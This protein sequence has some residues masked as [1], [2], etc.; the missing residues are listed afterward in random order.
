[1]RHRD[2]YIWKL[3]AKK[4]KVLEQFTA[5]GKWIGSRISQWLLVRGTFKRIAEKDDCGATVRKENVL[6]GVVLRLA[7]PVV[8]LFTFVFGARNGSLG[9]IVKKGEAL[10]SVSTLNP[11]RS[12]SSSS[13]REGA[14]LA[15]RKAVWNTGMRMFSQVL[16]LDW[17][18][19]KVAP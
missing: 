1:M 13:V 19:P 16:T 18:K 3:E 11:M 17:I 4:A 5:L 2:R 7:A 10:A 8:F 12:R 6:H 14:S 9:A 15:L